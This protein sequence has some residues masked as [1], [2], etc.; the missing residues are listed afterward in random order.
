MEI[1]VARIILLLGLAVVVAIGARRLRLPYTVGLALTGFALAFLRID[2]GLELTHEIV[3]DL[4]LP[5]P[6]F[7]AA[8]HLPGPELKADWPPMLAL[9]TLGV[10][11]CAGLVSGGLVALFGWPPAPA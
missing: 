3:F 9:S 10:L 11:L 6:L 7:E 5:P 4:I 2:I 8:L 1:L